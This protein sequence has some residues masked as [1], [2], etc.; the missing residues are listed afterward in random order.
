MHTHTFHSLLTR[1]LIHSLTHSL[2]HSVLVPN[3][4]VVAGDELLQSV[5]ARIPV[6][7]FGAGVATDAWLLAQYDEVLVF[8]LCLSV[9]CTPYCVCGLCICVYI[10]CVLLDCAVLCAVCCVL[11]AVLCAVRCALCAVRCVLCA[12]LCSL[13]CVRSL[14]IRCFV[15]RRL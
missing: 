14:L 4:S 13:C 9:L 10:V 2:T 1:L 6:A 3:S 11:C 8:T 15:R 7:V 5:C 12:V